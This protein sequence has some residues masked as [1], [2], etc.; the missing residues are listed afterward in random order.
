LI[1]GL[2]MAATFQGL[3]VSVGELDYPQNAH[4]VPSRCS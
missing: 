4:P 1:V 2:T 3:V